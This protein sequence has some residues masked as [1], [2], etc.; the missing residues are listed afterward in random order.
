MNEQPRETPS[1]QRAIGLAIEAGM[2]GLALALLL[3]FKG[4]RRF[5]FGQADFL[6]LIP[7]II[8]GGAIVYA[9]GE[10]IAGRLGGAFVAGVL[11]IWAGEW[12]GGRLARDSIL[13]TVVGPLIG[14]IIGAVI[15]AFADKALR[16]PKLPAD[17]E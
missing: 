4:W 15:G 13:Q 14:L 7:V 5:G 10:I 16:G 17:R 6:V 11:G 12:V 3:A 8:I 2:F 9:A 1:R